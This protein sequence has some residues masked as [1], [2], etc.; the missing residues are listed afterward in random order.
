MDVDAYVEAG[1]TR[2]DLAFD[3]P[4]EEVVDQ[5]D[6]FGDEILPAF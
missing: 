4:V 5:L 3:G 1:A 2:L 6:R